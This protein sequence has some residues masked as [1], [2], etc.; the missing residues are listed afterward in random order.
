M[1]AGL[2]RMAKTE[3]GKLSDFDRSRLA[4][5]GITA[6]DWTTLRGIAP[7]QFKGR[8]LLTPQAIKDG[9]GGDALAAKVFG[10]IHDESE[11]AVVNPDLA[12]RAVT[13][14]GGQQAGT[15]AG[16][17]AR[18]VMQFKSFPI[19]MFTRHWSRMLEGDHNAA[20]APLMANR[21]AYAFAL[22]AST[23]ALGA[24]ATQAKQIL[25]GKDPIDMQKPRFWAKAVAQGGGFGIAGDLFLID[26]AGS[27][28][29]SAT[30]AV[31]N[32]AGPTVG[33]VTDLVLKNITE[34]VWQAAEG[35]DT[36]WQA[37]LAT[38]AR[39]QTPGASLWWVKPMIEHGFVNAMNESMS[40]GYLARVQQRAQKDWG[41]QYWW[42]PKDPLPQRAPDLSAAT[43]G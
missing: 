1:N 23:T 27:A 41:Q 22:L 37:E 43:G 12:A 6:E 30:T 15:Y 3:W 10:L 40:P 39:Q 29:D 7:A 21:A 24:V 17:I 11:F 32:L 18:T 8:E 34:N 2:A 28:T 20:D 38:W 36:Q 31:K 13:T 33:T 35:K 19:S 16:E 5:S 9:G 14:F 26:P 25:S 4:R 42:A